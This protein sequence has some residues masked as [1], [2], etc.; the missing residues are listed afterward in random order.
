L[1]EWL[2]GADIGWAMRTATHRYDR[3]V[4]P[5][6]SSAKHHRTVDRQP[7]DRDPRG[8]KRELP[9]ITSDS[10]R[11]HR[12]SRSI[13]GSLGSDRIGGDPGRTATLSRG[14]PDRRARSA[15][16]AAARLHWVSQELPHWLDPLSGVTQTRIGERASQRP[17]GTV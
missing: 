3:A 2:G 4:R 1:N 16:E 10:R 9:P 17:D 5:G 6:R 14:L 15:R 11:G 7:V 13:R 12:T 8:G